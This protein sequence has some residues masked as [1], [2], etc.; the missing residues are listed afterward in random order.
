[1]KTRIGTTLGKH[2]LNFADAEEMFGG[3]FLFWPDLR[4]DYG[5][6]RWIGMGTIRGRTAVVAFTEGAP[7]T[8]RVISL[9]KATR[10]ERKQYEKAVQ[11]ELET[12]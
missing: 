12:S 6:S 5:E 2:G 8:I 4:K 10:H 1:M 11:D 7:D 9:R 3:I